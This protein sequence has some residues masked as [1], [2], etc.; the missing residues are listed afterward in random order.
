MS[1]VATLNLGSKPESLFKTK[2]LS[3]SAL[4]RINGVISASKSTLEL[5]DK[6]QNAR[7]GLRWATALERNLKATIID[8]RV[9]YQPRTHRSELSPSTKL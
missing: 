9:L 4:A 3:D 1:M 7:D 8:F 6:L 5:A 2:G